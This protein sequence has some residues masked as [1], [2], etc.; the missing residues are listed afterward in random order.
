MLATNSWLGWSE[1]VEHA[2]DVLPYSDVARAAPGFPDVDMDPVWAQHPQWPERFL[3]HWLVG[4][5]AKGTGVG[6]HAVYYAVAAI[7]VGLIVLFAAQILAVAEQRT[8]QV[9]GLGIVALSPYPARFGLV[10]PGMLTDTVFVAAVSGLTLA[11]LRRAGLGWVVLALLA[12]AVAR[13]QTTLPV[14]IVAAGW[15]VVQLR[16]RRARPRAIWASGALLA[17]LP[18]LVYVVQT[19]VGAS[20]APPNELSVSDVTFIGSVRD[21]GDGVRYLPA[22]LLGVVVPLLLPLAMLVAGLTARSRSAARLPTEFW[23]CLVLGAA[24][25]LQPL[26]LNP[27]FVGQGAGAFSS[28]IVSV[29]VRLSALGLVPVLAAAVIALRTSRVAVP[30]PVGVALCALVFVGSLHGDYTVVPAGQLTAATLTAVCSLAAL[31]LLRRAS[32]ARVERVAG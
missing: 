13:P 15:Y 8:I 6:L 18:A 4:L 30:T 9:V 17:L 12:A 23:G 27:R 20:F 25:A 22:Q 31:L 1:G 10:V 19:R 32:L 21:P 14:G 16:G 11:L 3:V 28:E 26:A 5:V 24:I 2:Y 29:Q 7:A